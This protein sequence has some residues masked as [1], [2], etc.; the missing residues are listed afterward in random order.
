MYSKSTEDRNDGGKGSGNFGHKGVEGQVGG[1][2]PSV[3]ERGKNIKCTGYRNKKTENKHINTHIKEFPGL[4]R[5]QYIQEGI[6]CLSQPCEGDVDGYIT[7][8]GIICRFNRKTGVMATGFP[9]KEICTYF[10]PRYDKK[11]GV[12]DIAASNR[13][14]DSCKKSRGVNA[15]D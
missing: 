2:A 3:S 5:K 10:K 4:T 11:K 13:Y 1:S 6:N 8:S 15:D 12:S 9:G 7:G 14:F